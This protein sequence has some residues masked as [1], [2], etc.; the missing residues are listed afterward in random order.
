MNTSDLPELID[1]FNQI[2][3][4]D[5]T[6]F[7]EDE[8]FE[9]YITCIQVMEDLITDNPTLIS[10]PDFDEIFNDIIQE[11]M[12]ATFEHDVSYTEEAEDEME[13]II[14]H[15]KTTFFKDFMPPR[16]YST[17][18]ILKKVDHSY[19]STQLQYLRNKPQPTQRTKEWYEFRHNLITASNAYKAFENKSNQNQLIFEKCKPL[20]STLYIDN[21]DK[22]KDTEIKDKDIPIVNVNVNTTLHW[23]QKYEPLSVKYYEHTYNTI[24]ED[25]GCI[26]HD[27][28]SFIGAS[29]DGINADKASPLYG[30]ML[31]IK[32]IVNREID[33]IPK[34]EYWIQMQLQMEV[35]NFNECDFL[36][37]KF[38]EYA[39]MIEYKN[40]TNSDTYEDDLGIEFKNTCLSKDNK[41]KGEIIYFHTI[42]GKPFYV[43]KPMDLI[44]P[45]D[46]ID[47]EEY[48]ISLYQSDKYNYIFIKFIYWK[49]EYVSCVLVCRNKQ[50]FKNNV[51]GLE[52]IWEIIKKE[53]VSGF[54]HRAPNRKTKKDTTL[55]NTALD[56]TSGTCFLQ[57]NKDTGK[58]TVIKKPASPLLPLEL[59]DV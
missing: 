26:Q 16:S 4:T 23:G 28:Y 38:I 45:Q 40:D 14:E 54:E 25:F 55:D 20:N 33:G 6:F 19:V 30:R 37:T 59:E 2:V 48:S 9:M 53:R 56:V 17:N 12:H 34:K 43:Y 22:D 58:I 11:E 46:I 13:E 47:W 5:D 49:L 29:P 3:P 10:D 24:I 31:E 18:I 27:K 36:E 8:A 57:F 7:S 51:A 44:H 52:S 41:M 39:D 1:I 35:C 42:E 50:W 32:N 15:A 21:E